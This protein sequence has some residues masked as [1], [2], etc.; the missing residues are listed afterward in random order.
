MQ[1]AEIEFPVSYLYE[2]CR[3]QEML[4]EANAYFNSVLQEKFRARGVKNE[5]HEAQPPAWISEE[6]ALSIIDKFSTTN[7]TAERL[8][9]LQEYECAAILGSTAPNM[10]ERM[11]YLVYLLDDMDVKI[12]HLF[13]LTGT[14]E[15]DPSK[16]YDGSFE[17]IESVKEKYGVR[18][19]SE[20][21]L[22]QDVHDRIC[23]QNA[24]C[25]EI[26]FNLIFALKD[27]GRATT[28]DTL[29]EFTKYHQKYHCVNTLYISVAPFIVYQNEIIAEFS[30]N[31]YKHNYETVG[32]KID[33]NVI[34]SKQKIAHYLVMTFA[35][36]FYAAQQ[37]IT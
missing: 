18:V 5:R 32:G 9:L 30:N 26:D 28:I 22:M 4:E 34:F 25:G 12:S 20:K 29:M 36:A 2:E 7:F 21:E 23:K 14:R 11:K 35:E 8:P 15:V 13:L 33:L 10:E 16:Y 1:I 6:I 24:I 27:S 3:S 19:V 17:Y 31:Y 37:R